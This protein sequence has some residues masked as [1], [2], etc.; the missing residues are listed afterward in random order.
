MTNEISNPE[1]A[2]APENENPNENPLE[3]NDGV[4]DMLRP[5]EK[6]GFGWL[7]TLLIIV[8]SLLVIVISFWISFNVGKKIFLKETPEPK[9]DTQLWEPLPEGS[10][11]GGAL[12]TDTPASESPAP[13]SEA[14]EELK[15][16]ASAPKTEAA[17]KPEII[18]PKAPAAPAPKVEAPAPAAAK[19]APAVKTVTAPKPAVVM[20]KPAAVAVTSKPSKVLMR[21][22]AGSFNDMESARR[23][24]QEL[25]QKGIPGFVWNHS[26]ADRTVYRVQVG[27]FS[28]SERAD[29]MVQKLKTLGYDA[30]IM[31]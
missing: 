28:Y 2:P 10:E 6:E 17:P 7:S 1:E 5:R 15:P 20:P 12:P 9:I 11:E 8:L 16:P 19:P 26:I 13:A 29:A 23:H 3:F 21:V 31:Q 25:S 14:S 4:G 24:V 18:A 22:I 30:Y 27:A